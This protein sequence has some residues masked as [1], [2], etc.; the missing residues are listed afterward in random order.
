MAVLKIKI[1]SIIGRMNELERVTAICGKSS[2]FHPDNS[3]SFYSDTSDFTPLNEENPYTEPLQRMKAAVEGSN[4]KLELV[5]ENAPSIDSYCVEDT[6]KYVDRIVPAFTG[7]H[8]QREKL[9]QEMEQYSRSIEEISHFTGI[10]LDL[11]E[12]RNCK[13]IKVRFGFLPR[14]SFERL[15]SFT[16]NPYVIFFP[17][18]ND[19]Q[20]YWGVYFAPIDQ[21][22]EVDRIFSRLYFERIQ[23]QDLN[24]SPEHS[25]EILQQKHEEA[26]KQIQKI[27]Q[28]VNQ[29]WEKEKDACLRLFTWLTE[30]EICF[31]IRRYAA[32]Y[33]D[34]FIVTGWIPEDYEEEFSKRLDV[35]STVDYSFADGKEELP[36]SPPVKLRNKKMFRPFE[37]FVNMYGLP[38]YNEVDPT[39]LVAITYVLLFGIMFGDAGQGI[40]VSIVGYLMWKL[41]QMPLGKILVPCGI[42]SAVFGVLYGSVFGF[43][44]AL[45]SFY[46]TVFSLPGKP[47]DVMDASSTNLIIGTAIAIGILL[48]I[49]A[50]LINIY[51]SLRRGAYEEALF[52]PNGIVGF[53][54]YTSV[55]FGA[56]VQVFV[57]IHVFSTA[58]ILCFQVVPLL[59]M[60][61]KEVLGGLVEHRAD[62]RPDNWV[63]YCVQNFFEVFE[64]ILSYASNTI[65]FLR[66][67][68]FVLVHAGMMNVVFALAGEPG[69]V[70]FI[71]VL[72]GNIIVMGLEGLLVGIQSLRL[73]YYELFSRF[74]EGQGRPFHPVIVQ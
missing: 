39:P 21:V 17:C 25:I 40:C 41:K 53:V 34:N 30:R 71:V 7:L 33:N 72:L 22:T 26:L 13:G 1:A 10:N 62:W 4:K 19:E 47:L 12:I 8:E 35:L 59:A 6:C 70:Y 55:I 14:E 15:N 9:Q 32:R 29:L 61:F 65:S 28:E 27:D 58:Y 45:D 49:F 43:E 36:H 24:G 66:V 63:E 11:D 44:H 56:L 54:F 64:Y 46:Q 20:N 73:E 42:S 37:F 38:S 31:G 52:G 60:F 2:M 51:S 68:A 48:V 18:T 50:I 23:L 57:G 69:I 16:E 67:G 5:R 74:F 3:L